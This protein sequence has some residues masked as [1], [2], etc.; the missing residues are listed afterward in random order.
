VTSQEI[1][2]CR[3]G[4]RLRERERA[5]IRKLSSG[6]KQLIACPISNSVLC[7]LLIFLLTMGPALNYHFSHKWIRSIIQY[8]KKKNRHSKSIETL[9]Q[10]FA[11]RVVYKLNIFSYN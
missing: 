1:R 5:K 7:G 3:R 11:Q 4:E 8:E 9:N 6:F 10:S 2:A